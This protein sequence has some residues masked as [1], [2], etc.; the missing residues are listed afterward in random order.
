MW[1][2]L[3]QRIPQLDHWVSLHKS[4]L[5]LQCDQFMHCYIFLSVIFT[6]NIYC[7]N[8]WWCLLT[9]RIPRFNSEMAHSAS[10]IDLYTWAYTVGYY[11]SI[12]YGPVIYSG[13]LWYPPFSR[14]KPRPAQLRRLM[15]VWCTDTA[16]PPHLVRNTQLVLSSTRWVP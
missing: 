5:M 3:T 14:R 11:F 8:L 4:T 10:M 1:L 15:N 7:G 6:P 13:S 16:H 12:F 9:Q 2:L